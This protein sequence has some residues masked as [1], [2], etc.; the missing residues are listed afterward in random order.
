MEKQYKDILVCTTYRVDWVE[1]IKDTNAFYLFSRL[2]LAIAAPTEGSLAWPFPSRSRRRYFGLNPI[3][4]GN[5]SLTSVSPRRVRQ[6]QQLPTFARFAS[7]NMADDSLAFQKRFHVAVKHCFKLLSFFTFIF[8]V[9]LQF[10][11]SIK[12]ISGLYTVVFIV[13]KDDEES[14]TWYVSVFLMIGATL[15]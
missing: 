12:F 13:D 8:A 4:R 14:F 9:L 3:G 6:R 2:K 15:V 1:I 11:D 7:K 10:V 5:I